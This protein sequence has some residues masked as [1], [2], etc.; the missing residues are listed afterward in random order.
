[1]VYSFLPFF[2]SIIFFS[3]VSS[4]LVFFK[5]GFFFINFF[6][7]FFVFK[8][9]FS[10]FIEALL[11]YHFFFI[12]DGFKFGFFLFVFREIIFFFSFFWFFFDII[13]VTVIDLGFFST[14]L[15][16]IKIN[17]LGLPFLNSLLL[18]SRAVILTFSH[19]SFLS[20]NFSIF[21]LFF[22]FFFGLIFFF[23]QLS[24]YFS[25]FFSFRDRVYGSLFFLLTGFH[26]LHVILGIFFLILNFFRKFE[27]SLTFFHHVGFEFS[28]LYW[29]FVDVIWLFLF[30]FVYWWVFFSLFYLEFLIS[31]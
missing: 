1:M 12:L 2:F 6:L 16:V 20:S 31:N 10:V 13:L 29:H 14:P 25:S 30:F 17:P 15:G 23:I 7:I 27:K 26:G 5:F 22:S 3:I 21:S 4:F 28:I 18:L 9:F 19:Y 8:W 11:G 24:E